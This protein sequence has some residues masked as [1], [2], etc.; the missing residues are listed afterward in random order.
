MMWFDPSLVDQELINDLEHTPVMDFAGLFH[1][2]AR[3]MWT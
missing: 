1:A 2:L 3:W